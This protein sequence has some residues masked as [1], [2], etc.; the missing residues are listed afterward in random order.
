MELIEYLRFLLKY[1]TWL[2]VGLAVGAAI[3]LGY[4][5][6][7]KDMYRATIS[8]FVQRQPDASS[9]STQYYTYDGFYAQQTAAA[10]TDNAIKLLTNDEIVTKAAQRA[11]LPTNEGSVAGLKSSIVAKK[12]APQLIQLSV[13]LAKHDQAAAFS[14][15]LAESLKARTNELNQEGDKRLAVDPVNTT[16][17]VV[18]ERPILF[19]YGLA[20]G[21][22]GLLLSIIVAGGW[23]YARHHRRR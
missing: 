15:G 12:D 4:A 1:W 8:L 22:L 9:S 19:L 11:G 21:V 14:I 13:L 18:L 5:Y 3:G 17:F 2:V 7:Q 10:Y 20:G 23:E 6:T 16:P